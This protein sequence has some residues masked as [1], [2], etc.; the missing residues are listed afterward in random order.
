MID[1][2]AIGRDAWAVR[3]PVLCGCEYLGACMWRWLRDGSR[4]YEAHTSLPAG[5]YEDEEALEWSTSRSC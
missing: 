5:L 2:S 1:G 4:A 3:P